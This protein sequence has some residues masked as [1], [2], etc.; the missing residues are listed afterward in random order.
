MC[1]SALFVPRAQILKIPQFVQVQSP[2]LSSQYILLIVLE[3]LKSVMKPFIQ[4]TS[5]FWNTH[6]RSPLLKRTYLHSSLFFSSSD[7]HKTPRASHTLS[8]GTKNLWVLTQKE[9]LPG[10][11]RYHVS[12]QHLLPHLELVFKFIFCFKFIPL[13]APHIRSASLITPPISG[14][15]NNKKIKSPSRNPSSAGLMVQQE[16]VGE[17]SGVIFWA[18]YLRGLSPLTPRARTGH[19]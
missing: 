10:L 18:G 17:S 12:F 13:R 8:Q 6:K 14:V 1:S 4:N 16:Q 19:S 9:E 15:V 11:P 7:I 5:R 3:S 2:V